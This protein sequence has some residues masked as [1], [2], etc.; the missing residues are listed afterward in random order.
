AIDAVTRRRDAQQGV[1]R[2]QVH[3]HV[4]VVPRV[5]GRCVGVRG[6]PV[7]LDRRA[8]GTL[9]VAGLVGDGRA[10][11]Q[12]LALAGDRAVGGAGPVDAGERVGAGPLDRDVA[13]VPAAVAERAGGDR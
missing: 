1:V 12:V 3:G 9:R 5:D 11:D 6:G 7:D 13:A 8:L 10:G 2:R 4:D